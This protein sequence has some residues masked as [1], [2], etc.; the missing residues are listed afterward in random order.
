[1][2]CSARTSSIL[3]GS[4]AKMSSESVA[5]LG[6]YI[7]LA[8]AAAQ[9]IAYFNWSNLGLILAVKGAGGLKAAGIS[10]IPLLVAFILV[11]ASIN[12][13]IATKR[14]CARTATTLPT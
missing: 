6:S 9:F 10:G 4:M 5:L 3:P 11:A 2:V 12:V 1:M 7:V 8:F 14:R 13:M